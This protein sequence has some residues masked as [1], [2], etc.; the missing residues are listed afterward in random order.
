MMAASSSVPALQNEP[1]QLL[2]ARACSNE[3]LAPTRQ[4]D[5]PPSTQ[6]PGDV[7]PEGDNELAPIYRAALL[8]IKGEATH[9]AGIHVYP[10]PWASTFGQWWSQMGRAM[11]SRE[12]QQWMTD[13]GVDP[14]T[15]VL[16]PGLGEISFRLTRERDPQ[17]VLHTLNQADARWAAISAPVLAAAKIIAAGDPA[18]VVKPPLDAGSE[19]APLDTIRRFYKEPATPTRAAAQARAVELL[20]DKSLVQ[21][22]PEQDRVLS[23]SRSQTVLERHRATLGDI[24][25]RYQAGYNLQYLSQRIEKGDDDEIGCVDE[26][27]KLKVYV[28]LDSSYKPAKADT[29]NGISLRQY[30]DDHGLN[31]PG[32]REQLVNLAKALMTPE[33]RAP[34]HG[35]YS[36]ALGWAEPVDPMIFQDLRAMITQGK[37]GGIDL[38]AFKSVLEYL[39]DKWPLSTSQARNPRLLIDNLLSSPKAKAL[40]AA[41]QA[42]FEVKS[43]KGRADDWLLAALCADAGTA[44]AVENADSRLNIEGYRLMAAGNAGKTAAAVLKELHMSLVSCGKTTSLL[45]ASAYTTLRLSF[46]APEFLVKEIPAA[47]VLGSHAWVSFVTA[48]GRIEAKSPGATAAMTYWQVMDYASTA[49]VTDE[50][51]RDEYL[52]QRHSLKDWAVANGIGLPQPNDTMAAVRTAFNAQLGELKAAALT[53]IDTVPTLSERVHALLKTALAGMSREQFEKKCI[54]LQPPNR[55]FPGPYSVLDLCMDGRPFASKP[56]GP[57][58]DVGTFGQAVLQATLLSNLGAIHATVEKPPTSQ[59]VSSSPD[60]DIRKALTAIESLGDLPTRFNAAF[61]RFAADLEKTTKAQLKYLISTLALQDRQNLEYGKMTVVKHMNLARNNT[62][63]PRRS[64]A[65]PGSVLVKTE[66]NGKFCTYEINRLTNKIIPRRDLGDFQTGDRT[67]VGSRPYTLFDVITP[68]GKYPPGFTD[69]NKGTPGIPRSFSSERTAYIVDAVIKDIDLP[70]ARQAAKGMTTFDTEVPPHKVVG[71]F[72]LNLIPLRSA[73]VNFKK[74]NL[75]DAANDLILD[76]FGFVMG[77]GGAAKGAKALAAGASAVGKAA[78]VMKI[79]GRAAVGSLNPLSGIDDLARSAWA[80]ARRTVAATQKGINY[81]RGATRSVDLLDVI[82][83]PDIAQGTY[84]SAQGIQQRKGLAKFDKAT[85]TWH[86]Y[87]PRKKQMYGGPRKDFTPES[88][89]RV[90][91]S[92]LGKIDDS[93]ISQGLSS[94]NVVRMGGPM[95]NLKFI[96]SQMHTFEDTYKGTTRLNISAHGVAPGASDP[97]LFNGTKVVVD[98]VA[99]DAEGLLALLKS[100]TVNPV[101][102]DTV[103]L[104]VCH[105][106]DGISTSFAHEF[107]KL[108]ER[109]V[110]AFEGPVTMNYGATGVTVDRNRLAVKLNRRYPGL[111]PDK[112]KA[113]ASILIRDEAAKGAA[114]HVFKRHGQKIIVDTTPLNGVPSSQE[115]LINY[116]PRHFP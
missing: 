68:T 83:H 82:K 112:A 5:M 110:K 18:A 103:R 40:G 8:E 23:E 39:L 25:I 7:H 113:M 64:R 41:I 30:L 116:R 46:Q 3:P 86:T 24:D 58:D 57:N 107:Q 52:A 101:H 76:I 35:D 15:V 91:G 27:T 51:Q 55:H 29:S 43:I 20:R 114:H 93:L 49:P 2:N 19:R 77:V 85:N 1:S 106:A 33:P 102:Y 88:A 12:M 74:G 28:P 38:G 56:P 95:Q 6:L 79:V 65:S 47:I 44:R 90:D 108:V 54:T 26:L 89:R 10:I 17:R 72:A 96:G 37:P 31:I 99:Y 42:A 105:G 60:V 34:L 87:D 84:K 100:K 59:W 109:P 53:A 45:A 67:D 50:E 62:G 71:E 61:S 73:I 97:L 32:N 4:S 13:V 111:T 70:A 115:T 22:P 14:M 69:E 16:K 98:G 92:D 66:R 36:G 9:D 48:V 78:H 21:L 81:L 94:D 80:G 63:Q 104:L 11:Q 75:S